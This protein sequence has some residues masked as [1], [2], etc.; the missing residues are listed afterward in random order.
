MIKKQPSVLLSRVY[1]R[2]GNW[3]RFHA[4]EMGREN[5]ERNP[6]EKN[7]AQSCETQRFSV[8]RRKLLGKQSDD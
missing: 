7:V 1:R 5:L 2:W 4:L 3:T 6:R 8:Y